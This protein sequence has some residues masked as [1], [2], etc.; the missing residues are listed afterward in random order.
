MAEPV[1]RRSALI[2]ALDVTGTDAV[3]HVAV[4]LQSLLQDLAAYPGVTDRAR[5]DLVLMDSDHAATVTPEDLL[6]RAREWS[7]RAT[8]TGAALGPLIDLIGSLPYEGGGFHVFMLLTRDLAS[9]WRDDLNALKTNV[10]SVTGLCCGP[11][12]PPETA[13]ALSKEPGGTR[14][15]NPLDTIRIQFDSIAAWLKEN[16]GTRPAGAPASEPSTS[17]K[18]PAVPV[19]QWQVREPT[20]RTDAVDHEHSVA[21]RGAKGW[22]LVGASRRGKLHAHEGTYRDDEFALGAF[23]EW[24]LAAVADGAGS[25]RLSRVGARVATSAAI[26]GMRDGIVRYWHSALSESP[27]DAL[28]AIVRAGVE[29]A[30]AAVYTEAGRR[31]IPVRD[32]SSTLLLLAHGPVGD[33]NSAWLGGAQI[34]DGMIVTVLTDRSSKLMGAADK[35]FYSG[36]TVFLT[37]LPE[38]EWGDRL[39]AVPAPPDLL[40]V[41]LMT[42]GVADDLVPLARQAPVLIDAVAQVVAEPTPDRKLLE[43]ISY[44]KRDSADDRTLVALARSEGRP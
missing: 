17:G 35:G 29:A 13:R 6:T 1:R 7:T 19:A 14:V 18:L 21:L 27:A 24:N 5:I 15:V 12:A 40:M 33:Q 2:F 28:R 41:L 31:K 30:S 3:Y 37:S 16:F 4:Y 38:A 39:W 43:T 10:G 42:D 22:R 23:Q 32:L 36:E 34:G 9:G 8:T 25:C 11:H 26:A 44:D 20:D